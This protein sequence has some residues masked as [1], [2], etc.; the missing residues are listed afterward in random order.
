MG[1]KMRVTLCKTF[2]FDAA[3]HLPKM[4]EGH[5]CRRMHGHTYRVDV[6]CEGDV[7]QDGLLVD[8]AHVAEAWEPIHQALDHRLLNEIPGLEDPTTE[9]LAHWI[10]IMLRTT[11]TLPTLPVT[12]VRVHESS[13]TWCEASR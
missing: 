6:V 11:P 13:T 5:K 2:D 10:L 1:F 8:Y 12:K 3:H 9:R 4:P 7:Q